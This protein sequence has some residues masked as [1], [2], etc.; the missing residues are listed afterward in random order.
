ME[1]LGA[2]YGCWGG[3]GGG[4]SLKVSRVGWGCLGAS[5]FEHYHR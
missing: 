4:W 2:G 1:D 3:G 5:G